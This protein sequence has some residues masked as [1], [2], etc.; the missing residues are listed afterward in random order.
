MTTMGIGPGKP[1]PATDFR[2]LET[3]Q[4]EGVVADAVEVQ[5]E[6]EMVFQSW[7]VATGRWQSV[8]DWSTTRLLG[9]D[10]DLYD[11]TLFMDGL[12]L[13]IRYALLYRYPATVSIA[14][15]SFFSVH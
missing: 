8:W 1:A 11:S 4:V 12:V 3:A 7:E 14:D 15:L 10:N 13:Y 6:V 2:Y 9:F 5:A